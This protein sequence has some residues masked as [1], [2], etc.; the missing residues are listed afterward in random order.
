MN[1]RSS[2]VL[3]LALYGTLLFNYGAPAPANEQAANSPSAQS[4][5]QRVESTPPTCPVDENLDCSADCRGFCPSQD[6]KNTLSGY[7]GP[8]ESAMPAAGSDPLGVPAAIQNQH[9][10]QFVIVT[11]SDPVHTRLSLFFDESVEAVEQAATDAGYLFARAAIPWDNTRHPEPSNFA[12]RLEEKD[13]QQAKENI[14]GLM[15]FRNTKGSGI[16]ETLLIFLVGELPTEGINK[17]QFHNALRAIQ[18]MSPPTGQGKSWLRVVGPTFSGSLYSL[19]EIFEQDNI[20]KSFLPQ[21][22][23]LSGTV[24]DPPT[25]RW[26]QNRPDHYEFQALHKNDFDAMRRF[27]SF[28][29]RLGYP[30]SSIARLSEDETAYGGESHIPDRDGA[31]PKKRNDTCTGKVPKLHFPRDIAS[32]RA[33]YEQE[34]RRQEI[35]EAQGK[36]PPRTSLRLNLEDTGSDDDSVATYSHAQ[37]PL[38]ED[39]VLKGIVSELRANQTRFIELRATSTLDLLFLTRY[40]QSAYPQGRIVT[41]IA[42]RLFDA[43]T[44]GTTMRGMFAL[45]SPALWDRQAAH[46]FTIQASPEEPVF[47]ST[48]AADVYTAMRHALVFHFPQT[49]FSRGPQYLWLTVLGRDGFWPIARLSPAPDD[50]WEF[51]ISPTISWMFLY[52]AGIMLAAM[53]ILF[54]W[55][56]SIRARTSALV[57]FAPVRNTAR[58][59]LLCI[60]AWLILLALLAIFAPA[61]L[62]G[63]VGSMALKA[64]AWGTVV[65]LITSTFFDL[66]RREEDH[67]DVSRLAS[68]RQ[69][70]LWFAAISAALVI[71]YFTFCLVMLHRHPEA[72]NLFLYRYI[73]LS[74]GVSPLLPWVMLLA[75]AL[76]WAWYGIKGMVL[77]DGR[78]PQLPDETIFPIEM[79]PSY[80]RFASLSDGANQRLWR[81]ARPLTRDTWAYIPALAGTIIVWIVLAA[82]QPSSHFMIIHG[83]EVWRLDFA[84]E[85]AL[86]LV[87]FGIACAL[88]QMGL[89]W[90]ACRNLLRGL[91][92]L[93]LRRGFNGLKEFSWRPIW[94]LSAGGENDLN[95]IFMREMESLTHLRN[96]P[97]LAS[98]NPAF[99]K[100]IEKSQE[101]LDNLQREFARPVAKQNAGVSPKSIWHRAKDES[102]KI[103]TF[104]ELRKQLAS[105]CGEGLKLL[106]SHWEKEDGL[107]SSELADA[108][109]GESEGKLLP[110][111]VKATEQFVC[112]IFMNFIFMGLRQV[113]NLV[114]IVAGMF[115][116]V[117]LS[118]SS[119]PFEPKTTLRSFMLL[120]L[121]ALAIAAAVIYAQMHRDPILSRITG[122]TPGKLGGD[123]WL[124]LAGAVGLPAL[125]L[126]AYQFPQVSNLLFSWLEPALQAI[127]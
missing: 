9:K 79:N 107:I 2:T 109:K 57:A 117:A 47:A 15:I 114:T 4:N 92:R 65:L 73:H 61:L 90:V 16:E 3:L 125:G 11:V 71:S 74:S 91:D 94:Q 72:G 93:P 51:I 101:C 48:N 62:P 52:F 46:D 100:A 1:K 53:Y 75:A 112:L 66:R 85:A 118:L 31:D 122:T 63:G 102:D 28:V 108:A 76:W 82:T 98:K 115:V 37:T 89:T 106:L 96:M 110:P 97:E 68:V 77:F 23:M 86:G 99:A 45:A 58:S 111:Y 35:A 33:A 67:S 21:V 34:L 54:S 32:L 29:C 25:I 40:L 124:R 83:V 120:L 38:S 6:F 17:R 42:N 20:A 5:L 126:L 119:Y 26:F 18:L 113:R 69:A 43:D 41:G 24:R 103:S 121:F 8:E 64:A 7:F 59:W 88:T 50:S 104:K 84:Y 10:L 70:W 123:F 39:E 81:A 80:I 22:E 116:F 105:T 30:L 19:N 13:Y 95:T 14:P 44:G 60:F 12:T 78:L 55:R 49:A 36:R 87:L 127:K 56:G 27:E